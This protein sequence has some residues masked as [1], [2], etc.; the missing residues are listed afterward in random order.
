MDNRWCGIGSGIG[1]LSCVGCRVGR[2]CVVIVSCSYYFILRIDSSMPES[3]LLFA[4]NFLGVLYCVHQFQVTC[5]HAF[6]SKANLT[7]R[8]MALHIFFPQRDVFFGHAHI[9]VVAKNKILCQIVKPVMTV[10]IV[11]SLNLQREVFFAFHIA[12]Y[13]NSY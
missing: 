1:C 4:K 8:I 7:V 3:D 5:G 11:D 10:G 13:C 6:H 12:R 2:L 9:M